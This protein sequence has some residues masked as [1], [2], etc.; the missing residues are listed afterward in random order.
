MSL[1]EVL[2]AGQQNA[3]PH[4][5]ALARPSRESICADDWLLPVLDLLDYG[6][7]L[8]D[9]GARALHVNRTASG[10]LHEATLLKLDEGRVD[11][12]RAEDASAWR[13][14]LQAAAR[15]GLRTLLALGG[16]ARTAVSV[17]PLG[18]SSSQPAQ[19]S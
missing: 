2:Q 3:R 12:A 10:L 17:I 9:A 1:E 16:P 4:P 15:R 6:I 14:A 5:V 18:K 19:A 7:L 11:A 8:L 13:A